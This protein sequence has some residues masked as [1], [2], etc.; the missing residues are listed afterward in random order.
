MITDFNKYWS[1]KREK[2]V[3]K[4]STKA[5][6]MLKSH[7]R[8]EDV[9]AEVF[10]PFSHA[11]GFDNY[12]GLKHE[13]YCQQN[14]VAQWGTKMKFS[15]SEE[16]LREAL[17]QHG[18]DVSQLKMECSKRSLAGEAAPEPPIFT[19]GQYYSNL[20]Y[21][22]KRR[23]NEW[24]K[25]VYEFA[26]QLETV[27]LTYRQAVMVINRYTMPGVAFAYYELNPCIRLSLNYPML[28]QETEFNTLD[29]S[30]LLMEMDAE[31]ELRQDEFNYL[32]KQYK[33]LSMDAVT[34]SSIE[35]KVLE[36]KK[37]EAKLQEYEQ[38]G[39][40]TD[41]KLEMVLRPWR[42]AVRNFL[43][44]VTHRD[45]DVENLRINKAALF[46]GFKRFRDDYL[47]QVVLPYFKQHMPA[48]A[49]VTTNSSNRI[50]IEYKGYHTVIFEG[51]ST[52]FLL[53]CCPQV[54]KDR[55]FDYR[56]LG[57]G[58][59]ILELK[60]LTLSAIV[61]YVKLT[62]NFNQRIIDTRNKIT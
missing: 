31:C 53:L 39:Y 5:R 51:T 22:L 60:E 11:L 19:Q 49:V 9:R 48:E 45:I 7:K 8:L 12:D 4:W 54:V 15:F 10:L 29:V 36:G 1:A 2:A 42:T 33:I 37:L 47:A 52:I 34:T 55:L 44:N 23:Y 35:F 62:P 16:R 50:E 61:E 17:Q 6:A 41:K 28:M 26:D 59:N 14:P 24:V 25:R 13:H 18:G 57:W 30:S 46:S 43:E 27:T 58:S 3:K 21:D 38:K 56:R 32:C 40:N 20:V